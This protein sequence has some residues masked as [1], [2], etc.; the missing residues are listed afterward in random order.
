MLDSAWHGA[1]WDDGTAVTVG[2]EK[3]Q[4][5]GP[6]VWLQQ[7]GFTMNECA[8]A[9]PSKLVPEGCGSTLRWHGS[10]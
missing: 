2:Q 8:G 5:S 4:G 3:L 1:I 6:H 10:K 9:K 7:S